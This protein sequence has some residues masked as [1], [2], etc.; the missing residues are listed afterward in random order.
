MG[1]AI[2]VPLTKTTKERLRALAKIE[3]RAL[4]REAEHLIEIGI[5][6]SQTVQGV[7]SSP[8]SAREVS[9]PDGTA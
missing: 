4:G 5:S 2:T 7:A 8:E 9:F 1:N 6:T 3:K